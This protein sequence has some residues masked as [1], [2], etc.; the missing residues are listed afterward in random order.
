MPSS[1]TLHARCCLTGDRMLEPG[2]VSPGGPQ[3]Q[4]E[5]GFAG[6]PGARTYLK[7]QRVAYPFHLC[8][9]LYL[10]GDPVEFCTVYLQSCSGGIFQADRLSLRIAAQQDARVHLTT[11]ASTVVHTMN[12]GHAEQVVRLDAGPGSYVEY[13][14]DPLILFPRARLRNALTVRLDP[15]AT[16]VLCDSFLAHDP[17]GADAT[18]DWLHSDTQV[19]SADG[20]ILAVDRFE[21]RGADVSSGEIGI[22]GPF[23]MQATLMVLHPA[24]PERALDA[25]RGVLPEPGKVYAGASL[26][27][28]GCGAWMRAVSSDAVALRALVRDGWA[29]IRT[30]LTGTPPGIR[31]K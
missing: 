21:V 14:P 10:P 28:G 13:L 2:V 20:A 24:A 29:A 6:S 3:P 1:I 25:L 8:R 12:E 31:R 27:P 15:S 30:A 11:A 19:E 5:I 7:R 9:A 26:L 23:A 16:V 17:A 4:V 22:H 18:F